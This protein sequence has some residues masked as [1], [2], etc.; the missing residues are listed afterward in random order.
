MSKDVEQQHPGTAQDESDFQDSFLKELTREAPVSVPMPVTGERLGGL[1][2]KRY[3]LLGPLGGGGMG[4]VFRALDHELRRTVAL[5]FLLPSLRLAPSERAALLREEAQATARLSHENIVQIYDVSEWTPLTREGSGAISWRI[6]FIVME[7]LEGESLQKLLRKGRLELRRVFDILV[8]V[9][10]G[11]AH[12]HARGIVHRD[13]KPG[14][15]FIL[16]SG[17]AK[18]LDF[19]LARLEAGSSMISRAAWEGTP[20]YMAP[21]QWKG[22]APDA[23]VDIWAAGVMLFEMLTGTLPFPEEGLPGLRGLLTSSEP[24][25]GVRERRA[26]VPVELERLV[27]ACLDK[28]PADRPA[29][30]AALLGRLSQLREHLGLRLRTPQVGLAGRR[31]VT[32]MACRLGLTGGSAEQRDPEDLGE[33]EAAFH[34]ACTRIIRQHGGAITTAVGAE[35]LACFGYPSIQEQDSEN[36]VRAALRLKV[37][38]PQALESLGPRGLSVSVGIHTDLVAL[39]EALPDFHG[40]TPAMQGEAPKVASWLA[41]RAGPDTMLLSDQTARLVRGGFQLHALGQESFEGLSGTSRIGLYQVLQERQRESRFDR[42]LVAGALT[43]LV[44]RERE[45]ER[46]SQWWDEALHG[47]GLFVLLRGEAGI[48]KSRLLQELHDREPRDAVTWARCQCWPQFRN[49]AFYPLLDWLQRFLQ[50]SAT[51]APEAKTRKVE[52]RL[53][54]LGLRP[55][56]AP[57]L[58]SLLSLPVAAGSPFLRLTPELQRER[59]MESLAALLRALSGPRPLA[60]VVEDLHWADPSTLQFLGL[61]LDKLRDARACVLLTA[62]PGFEHPWARQPR[63]RGMELEPLPPEATEAMILEATRDR[64]LP[65]GMLGGLVAR[66]DGIPLYIEELTR[67]MREQRDAGDASSEVRPF[68][69]P[70]TLREL[71]LARLDQL[72]ARGKALVQLAATLGR[73]FNHEMLLAVSFLREDELQ[74]EL[75]LLERA[76]LLFEQ[77]QPPYRLH[78]FKHSLIQE[79][80]YQSLLRSTRQR[81][82]AR[83]VRVMDEQFPELTEDHPE[84]VAQ[85][86]TRA[87]L[88]ERALSEWQRAGQQAAAKSAFPEALS[89]FAQALGQLARL[90][91]SARRDRRELS[92][93]LESGNVLTLTKGFTAPEVEE[94]FARAR[95][96]SEQSGDV[97]PHVLWGLIN[98]AV[99]RGDREGMRHLSRHIRRLIEAEGEPEAR[100]VAHAKLA[101]WEFWKGGYAACVWHCERAKVLAR[102]AGVS[103]LLGQISGGNAYVSESLLYAHLYLAYAKMM[104]GE[105]GQAHREYQE[106]LALAESTHYPYAIATVL[107]FGASLEYESDEPEETHA[108]ASRTIALSTENRFPFTLAIGQCFEGW[109]TARLGDVRRGVATLQEGLAL[110]KAMGALVVCPRKLTY[111]AAAWLLGGRFEE[112]LATVKEGLELT[113]TTFSQNALP[114]LLRLQG[115]LLLGL[116]DEETARHSLRQAIAVAHR[117]GGGLH[118]LRAARSLARLPRRNEE[119]YT[120]LPEELGAI[121]AGPG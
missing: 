111:L 92:L 57:P 90:P 41:A 98:V 109:A 104:K 3:E 95:R 32:L 40:T 14:N 96:L 43:P 28:N 91:P 52:E 68:P 83:I 79:A 56:H 87:G 58:A 12:A 21:E 112:G 84:W 17:R 37:A 106:T 77:G 59:S 61:L 76:G 8:D 113:R 70:S 26:N 93:L 34:G 120:P 101:T 66:T 23:R 2:G 30:G 39:G 80:A 1:E 71:L 9:A 85:H 49:S 33:L 5:K 51:D 89:H 105:C 108:I 22:G 60:F 115:E 38:I 65:T 25:P 102:E 117:F 35:V 86:A 44:G 82:H 10:T 69:I 27:A 6:P 64:P 47:P 15:V 110:L 116:G 24:M 103:R 81:Y 100:I 54:A 97:P 73:E 18:I 7:Y 29:D 67:M 36:A 63:Y 75:E 48:G 11:L 62:R 53:D 13:L 20:A 107:M 50:L 94:V 88:V 4:Q 99:V 119:Q 42:A 45:L 78:A 114:E 19:G 16:P 121:L 118:E 74:R 31:Q 55:E 72:P 46:L